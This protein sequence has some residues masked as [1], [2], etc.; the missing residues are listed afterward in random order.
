MCCKSNNRLNIR[1]MEHAIRRNFGGF[2]LEGQEDIVEIFM[3]QV[4]TR[5]PTAMPKKSEMKKKLKNSFRDEFKNDQAK[6]DQLYAT[7]FLSSHERIRNDLKGPGKQVDDEQVQQYCSLTF[8]KKWRDGKFDPTFQVEYE[9]QYNSFFEEKFEK[10]VKPTTFY[11]FH[12][13]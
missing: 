2:S 1:Q 11:T 4:K 8:Q 12:A 9:K 5:L 10:E 3:K 13:L 6:H 7:F